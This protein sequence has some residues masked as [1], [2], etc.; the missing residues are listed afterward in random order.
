MVVRLVD[1]T[2]QLPHKSIFI[3]IPSLEGWSTKAKEEP[4][5]HIKSRS[6]DDNI[7]EK[8]AIVTSGDKAT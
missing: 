6:K 3:M 4:S 5:P 1:I 7:R 2:K 8:A